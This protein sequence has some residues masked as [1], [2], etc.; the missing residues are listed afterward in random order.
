MKYAELKD[1]KLTLGQF[2]SILSEIKSVPA[3]IPPRDQPEELIKVLFE[4]LK[5]VL[6]KAQIFEG[7]SHSYIHY[8]NILIHVNMD[9]RIITINPTDNP[10]TSEEELKQTI[11]TLASIYNIPIEIIEEMY[12]FWYIKFSVKELKTERQ[13]NK[14]ELEI[15]RVSRE[16]LEQFSDYAIYNIRKKEIDALVDIASPGKNPRGK[17]LTVGLIRKFFEIIDDTKNKL[18]TVKETEN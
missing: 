12:G 5:K 1:A 14:E 7:K 4:T 9:S 18:K 11:N 3:Y 6:T 10:I 8:D 17:R 2:F 16:K 15:L 13:L